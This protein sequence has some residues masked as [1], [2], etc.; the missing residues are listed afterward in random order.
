MARVALILTHP[1]P[2]FRRR[3]NPRMRMTGDIGARFNVVVTETAAAPR[4]RQRLA[5]L[6]VVAGVSLPGCGAST[7]DRALIGAGIGASAG[8]IG[9]A[10]IGNPLAGAAIGAAAGAG[11]GMATAPTEPTAAAP[12]EPTVKAPSDPDH[13]VTTYLSKTRRPKAARAENRRAAIRTCGGGIALIN[14]LSG[15]DAHGAWLQ[16][17]YGCIAKDEGEVG[18]PHT[19]TSG[20]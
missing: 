2:R 8:A 17:V 5:S 1:S 13:I 14:E 9:G 15:A 20:R 7:T 18:Q 16:L 6:I 3:C 4:R 12:T 19:Q 10:L 11:V